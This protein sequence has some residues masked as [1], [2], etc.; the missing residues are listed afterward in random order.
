[1][2]TEQEFNGIKYKFFWN[3]EFSNWFPSKFV[4]DEITFNCGEQYMMFKKAITFNNAE[5]AREI[6]KEKDP[7]K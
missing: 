6:L 1:M 2:K 4:I 3:G 7:R 5:T